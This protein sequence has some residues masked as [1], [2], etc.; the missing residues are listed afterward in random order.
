M[1]PRDPDEIIE[2]AERRS[3]A[4]AAHYLPAAEWFLGRDGLLRREEAIDDLASDREVDREVA[5]AVVG[6]LVGDEVDPVQQIV[7][8]G[9]DRFVGVIDHA[10]HGWF[11][12]YDRYDDVDG[13]ERRAVCAHCVHEER[14][15]ANVGHVTRTP[16][17]YDLDGVRLALALHYHVDHEGRAL[18]DVLAADLGVDP[19]TFAARHGLSG[20]G[21]LTLRDVTRRLHD[22]PALRSIVADAA[23]SLSVPDVDVEP[24]AS[25]VSGTTIGGNE[26]WHAG[27]DGSG[28]GLHADFL[29]G[30]HAADLRRVVRRNMSGEP[31]IVDTNVSMTWLSSFQSSDY[32]TIT[33]SPTTSMPVAFVDT[34][35]SGY[36]AYNVD[37]DE[38]RRNGSVISPNTAD[39]LTTGVTATDTFQFQ[40]HATGSGNTYLYMYGS[41]KEPELVYPP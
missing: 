3:D 32:A 16:S 13:R 22:D 27:N 21:A 4:I 36:F 35:V 19:A 39:T 34:F 1:S 14:A 7:Q 8:P 33:L 28:S 26:S 10:E 9:G 2:E 15:A 6:H 40:F 38:I 12:A 17:A 25:L 31:N 23:D 11:Y 30:R 5:A 24:G 18:V 41:L 20:P 29:D 37:L